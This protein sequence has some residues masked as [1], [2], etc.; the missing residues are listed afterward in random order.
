MREFK[1]DGA[2]QY[3]M[4]GSF[5]KTRQATS[6]RT[7]VL[8]PLALGCLVSAD[9]GTAFAFDRAILP[10]H[11]AIASADAIVDASTTR[12]PEGA[13]RFS[14]TSAEVRIIRIYK[15]TLPGEK[16]SVGLSPLHDMA[17]APFE[18]GKRYLLFLSRTQRSATKTP[19]SST[20]LFEVMLDGTKPFDAASVAKV[21]AAIK[22]MPAWSPPQ[23]GLSCILVPEE[24][25]VKAGGHIEMWAGYKNL[26]RRAITLKYRDWP[27]QTHT[28]WKLQVRAGNGKAIAPRAHPHLTRAEIIDFFSKNPHT[29]DLTLQPG[30]TFRLLAALQMTESSL[31][32]VVEQ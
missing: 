32:V 21:S 13:S 1:S 27:L 9:A 4:H 23:R 2:E 17:M 30:Q 22:L 11:T 5:M 7:I 31:R 28:H 10:L 6:I 12:V 15:G 18:K 19:S 14:A 24:F 26:S 3:P 8:A 29:F 20:P 16:L 25:K